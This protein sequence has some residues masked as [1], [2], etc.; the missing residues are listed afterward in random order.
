MI[1]KEYPFKLDKVEDNIITFVDQFKDKNN[2]K[3]K[4]FVLEKDIIRVMFI[5]DKL[6]MEKTWMVA[7]NLADVPYQGRNK[8][9]VSP[10][11]LPKYNYYQKEGSFV[12]ETERLRA[13]IDLDGFKV[14]W[15]ARQ[16]N[17]WVKIAADRKTQSYNL[18]QHFGSGIY[19]YLEKAEN[20]KYYGLGEK[21]GEI[22]KNDNRYRMTTIDAMGYDAEKS[23]P[24]YKYIPFYITRNTESEISYGLFYDNLSEA[25]FDFAREKDNYHGH[26]RYYFAESGDLDYYMILGP[27]MKAVTRKFSWL[28]GENIFEPK[29]SLGYSGSTMT[30][31]DSPNAQEELMKF[32]ADC[33][34]HDIPCDSFQLSSGYTSIDDK[35]YVFNWNYSKIPDP[36]KM[37]ATF[38]KNGIKLCAN[39]KP[40][41]L[42]DHPRYE[43]AKEKNLF[44]KNEKGE[45]EVSQF[46]DNL[47]SYL[48][49]T[50]QDTV[51]WWKDNVKTNCLNSELILPGTIIMNMRS[52]QM[53]P[54]R[55]VLA[56][57]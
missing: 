2:L 57:K 33:D 35:R 56:A 53:M 16:G 29:W 4:V 47:G 38:N 30:Y 37:S 14:T 41:L 17:D 19:H 27:E 32:I 46:W 13:K 49:F 42:I 34:R 48:D 50:N 20:D 39:I 18:N 10:F 23:D 1:L 15:Y 45:V 25:V 36:E 28:S 55:M 44:I 26:Y 3:V 12:V 31:T 5:R 11:S 51:D 21:A 7:P 24:L 40:C 22:E 8:F 52:G 9:D 43:E 54:M 6:T